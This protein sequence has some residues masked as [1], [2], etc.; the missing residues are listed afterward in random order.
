MQLR[1]LVER[2]RFATRF[3]RPPACPESWSTGAPDFIG[4]G[5][6]RSGTTWWYDLIAAH[7]GVHPGIAKELHLLRRYWQAPFDTAAADRYAS[8]FPRPAGQLVGE[9]SP[10]YLPH[11]WVPPLL[12]LAAPDARFLVMLR[13]PVERYQ[14]GLALRARTRSLK[15]GDATASFRLGLYGSQ[16]EHLFR[17]VDRDRVLVLQFERCRT[18]PRGELARTYRFLGLDDTVVPDDLSGVRNESRGPK[19]PLPDQVRQSLLRAYEPDLARLGALD[20]GL[21]LGLWPSWS[22]NGHA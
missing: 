2:A 22:S 17:C 3:R 11:F 10:G 13:D 21:D 6:Q 20:L 14:S 7:P 8:F 4:L 9:W 15:F 12:T 18:D 19:P 1:A 16:L 5:A